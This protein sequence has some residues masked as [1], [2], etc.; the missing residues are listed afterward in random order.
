MNTFWLW[1]RD[2]WFWL[3]ALGRWLVL[4]ARQFWL[5]IVVAGGALL[6]SL[7]PGTSEQFIRLTGMVLQLLGLGTVAWEIAETRAQ[8]NKAHESIAAYCTQHP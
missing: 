1:L 3:R 2:V 8:S 5:A 7:Q 4:D 6:I